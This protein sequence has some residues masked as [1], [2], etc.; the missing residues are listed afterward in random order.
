[1][2]YDG[3]GNFTRERN[4]SADAS[5]GIKILASAMD[6]EFDNFASAA[7]QAVLRG[8]QNQP[9]AD[10][11]MGGRKHV[12]VAAATSASN[13][14]RAREYVAQVP[15][16]TN[17]TSGAKTKVCV[18]ADFYASVS[19]NQAP[20]DGS[21]LIIRS[22][23]HK[24]GSCVMYL[25]GGL[26]TSHSANISDSLGNRIYEN[27]IASG[28]LY[29]F[30]FD[31][32][33]ASWQ[34]LNPAIA[35]VEVSVNFKIVDDTSAPAS[36]SAIGRVDGL[37]LVMTRDGQELHTAFK[38][39]TNNILSVSVSASS[40]DWRGIFSAIPQSYRVASHG[41][42]QVMYIKAGSVGTGGLRYGTS[43]SAVFAPKPE[44]SICSAN[45][46]IQIPSFTVTN[47]LTVTTS[48]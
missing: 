37:S 8:G 29:E 44:P 31:A 27:A 21:R 46:N 40:N 43:G 2:G 23:N 35:A 6:K 39:P 4:F 34:I 38:P 14:L 17:D 7:E 36:T 20:P 26:G 1:M 28:G 42:A 5:A 48:I 13:Y 25:N 47:L 9:T 10:L 33:A 32:S 19:A 22:K 3:S 30:M 18:S 15:I 11:P 16:F 45:I 24:N 12:N 41:E